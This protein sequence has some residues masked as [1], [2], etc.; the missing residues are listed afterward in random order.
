MVQSHACQNCTLL[1]VASSAVL[2]PGAGRD[3]GCPY[4][5]IRKQA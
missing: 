4:L 1:P 2:G 5:Y 3:R